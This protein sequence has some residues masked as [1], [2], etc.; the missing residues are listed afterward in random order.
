MCKQGEAK[1]QPGQHGQSPVSGSS[2][3]STILQQEQEWGNPKS[4]SKSSPKNHEVEA[5]SMAVRLGGIGCIAS[6]VSLPLPAN[7]RPSVLM[8]S[9][10]GKQGGK[11]KPHCLLQLLNQSQEDYG[12]YWDSTTIS[13]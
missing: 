4:K 13:P 7:Q 9:P 5:G 8:T 6:R 12:N 10:P 11:W 3:E 1:A 2:M